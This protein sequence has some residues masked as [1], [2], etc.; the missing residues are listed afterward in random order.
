MSGSP[1]PPQTEERRAAP[2]AALIVVGIHREERDFGHEVA[3]TLPA[4]EAEVLEIPE[5]LSNHRPRPD[6]RF[7]HEVLHQAL[8]LQLLPQ[9]K[10]A[11]RL[12]ID[13]HTG[14]DGNGPAADLLCADP[15]LRAALNAA[16]GNA[17]EPCA[18]Q[19]RVI[20]LGT[21]AGLRARTVIPETVWN[22]PAFAYLGMEIYLP[23]TA[24]G[25]QQ[26]VDL[27]RR[28]IRLAIRLSGALADST[29]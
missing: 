27:A 19:V 7:R 5:G 3:L 23:G 25:R 9:L 18:A 12:L 20:P 4:D 10:P 6:E 13:L 16:L 17:A 26:G 14:S 1:T 29:A 21:P 24:S 15:R 11:H 28:L 22:N 8:Y 2:P